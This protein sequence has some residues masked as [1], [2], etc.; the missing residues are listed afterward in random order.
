[1]TTWYRIVCI[2]NKVVYSV[3]KCP[4][5]NYID[6]CEIEW[7][8]RLTVFSLKSLVYVLYIY[9]KH[10]ILTHFVLL[11]NV[12]KYQKSVLR[13]NLSSPKSRHFA[14]QFPN[15]CHVWNTI[16]GTRS[17][18]TDLSLYKRKRNSLTLGNYMGESNKVSFPTIC[19]TVLHTVADRADSAHSRIL[20][21]PGCIVYSVYV[22]S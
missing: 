5:R 7:K 21:C 11:Y 16:Y 12:I 10:L 3:K 6:S 8:R 22:I 1:M 20:S 14:Q 9:R 2:W 4:L 13:Q 15:R 17:I 19:N 18:Y